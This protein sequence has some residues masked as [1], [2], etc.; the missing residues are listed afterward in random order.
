MTADSPTSVLYLGWS[1]DA[2]DALARHGADTT[3]AVTVA[4]SA[5]ADAHSGCARA[6]VVP[7]PERIDDVVA[8]LLREGI[9]G[10]MF[11]HVC[12][13]HEPAIVPTAV[14]AQAYGRHGMPI[15]TAVALRD[16]FVQK[17][18]VRAAGL[19]V[20]GC[21]IAKDLKEIASCPTPFVVKPF[22]GGGT[23]LTY[24]VT[25]EVSLAKAVH[26]I[27]ASGEAGPWLVEEFMTG[28]ELHVDGVVRDGELR[29]FSVSRY[30]QNVID[31]QRGLP[32]G[33]Y[34]VDP[35]ADPGLYQ[36]TQELVSASLAALGHTDGVFHLEMFDDDGRLTFSET[37]GRIGGGL[38]WEANI[39]KFGVDLYDEWARAA[40]GLPSGIGADRSTN[41]GSYGWV[42]LSAR[43]GRVT[44]IPT[45]DELAGRP[46]VVA[47]QVSVKPGDTVPDST[48]GSHIR[49]ARVLMTG[50]SE[51]SV[52][53]GLRRFAQWF[54]EQVEVA[55]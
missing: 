34:T 47:A 55:A 50:D 41:T 32:V 17:A 36:A 12:T 38:L 5:A 20:A 31:L 45:V 37:A 27:A 23:Q 7:D 8:G 52:A 54:R 10:R 22:D 42:H 33:S 18:L 43:P 24:A 29:F 9:D 26:D 4:D 15:G 13:E 51:D 44:A 48:T 1:G 28:S 53:D 30:L 46:G 40:L 2:A 11:D 16:K 49:V 21:R 39:L 6:V 25:G 14:L 19:P 35:S 3:F